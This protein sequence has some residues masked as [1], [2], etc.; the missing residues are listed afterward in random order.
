MTPPSNQKPVSRWTIRRR[1][2]RAAQLSIQ[3]IAAASDFND[4]SP[5]FDGSNI[6]GARENEHHA[7]TMDDFQNSYSAELSDLER[8]YSTVEYDSELSDD[9]H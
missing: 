5:Y 2:N 1:A 4:T 3:H 7:P 9:N 6:N 8:A